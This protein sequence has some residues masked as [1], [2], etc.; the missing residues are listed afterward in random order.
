MLA[1][2]ARPERGLTDPPRD[3]RDPLRRQELLAVPPHR[4]RVPADRPDEPRH[5]RALAPAPAR[6]RER[7][8]PRA[9]E[10]H[11][12]RPGREEPGAEGQEGNEHLKRIE[13]SVDRPRDCRRAERDVRIPDR[14]V[15]P[16]HRLPPEPAR[17]ERRRGHVAHARQVTREAFERERDDGEGEE[18]ERGDVRAAEHRK[19]RGGHDFTPRSAASAPPRTLRRRARGAPRAPPCRARS[20]RSARP[21]IP[22]GTARRSRS[23][24]G[25]ARR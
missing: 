10:E 5:E 9:A 16:E 12:E 4:R 17:G 13:R 20:S 22:P 24:R 7:V 2:H 1:E 14:E 11:V 6:A 8:S 19:A 18:P 3:P 15:P 23:R 21:R 25:D